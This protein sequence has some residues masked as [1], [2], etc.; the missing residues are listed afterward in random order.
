MKKTRV[1]TPS[2]HAGFC[3]ASDGSVIVA[4]ARGNPLSPGP[5][6]IFPLRWLLLLTVV[7]LLAHVALLRT[8]PMSLG[9]SDP[10][11]QRVFTT[12]LIEPAWPEAAPAV[13]QPVPSAA[14]P[15][16]RG[17]APAPV[18]TAVPVPA[19]QGSDNQPPPL[20]AQQGAGS[21]ADAAP[22]PD[23]PLSEVDQLS[24]A[25]PP[26]REAAV[27]ASVYTPPGP[28]TLKYK[29]ESS[30]FPFSA[31]AELRWQPEGESY[32]ARL[33]VSVFGQTRVQTSRGQITA[34]GLAPV[35]FSD[36]Y[37]SEVAA[38]FDREKGRVTFSAN[39]P[40]VPLLAGAQDRLSILVQLAAMIAGDPEHYP[41]ATTITVQ[42]IGPRDADTW[43]FTVGKEETLILPGGQQ[44]TLKL[45]RNPRQEFDQTVEL[46]LAPALGYLPARI[47]ITE[48]NGDFVDQKWLATG[49]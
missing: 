16:R 9:V 49:P 30:K 13:R 22:S 2:Q 42:T 17:A 21:P 43:L 47:R 1:D 27:A 33:A 25:P 10:P 15:R 6:R 37:R 39:T 3:P 12:R 38:H 28:V 35:R 40:D 31:G 18:R 29:V 44:A 36:K 46:W 8:T 4:A 20:M 19:S 11:L 5:T 23:E 45:I 48:P 34:Q 26:P 41:E 7:V 32:D 24:S 14:T